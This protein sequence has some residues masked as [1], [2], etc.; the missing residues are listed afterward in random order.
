MRRVVP[1]LIGLA[2]L[3]TVG[4]VHGRWTDRWQPSTDLV[5]AADRVAQLPENIG[6]WKG[7]E[8][9][10]D[11]E[12]L[13]MAGAVGHYSRRFQD[14]QTGEQVLVILLVGKASRL[15]VHRPEHCYT[16]AGY[17][18]KNQPTTLRLG[19]PGLEEAELATGLFVRDEVTGPSQLRIFWAFG[20]NHRWSAPTSPRWAFAREP[21]LYKL[22]LIRGVAEEPGSIREDP[23]LRL[24]GE[25]LPLL[26]RQ[27]SW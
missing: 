10:Q 23:S 27:L 1:L 6:D 7:Q 26:E 9:V 12:A 22:Y 18:I 24:L 17:I 2:V 15:V 11:P 21:L 4:L 3:V 16:T 19:I 8:V 5:E 20:A 13:A 14:P 25:L